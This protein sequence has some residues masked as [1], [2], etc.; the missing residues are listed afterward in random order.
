MKRV[1]ST[2][3]AVSLPLALAV[4]GTAQAESTGNATVSVLHGVPGLTVDVFANGEELIP[5]FEPGTLTDPLTIPAGTYDIQIFPDGEGPDGEPAI[6]APGVEVP[7]GVNATI[8][9]HLTE[10]GDPTATV[11]VNDLTGIEAGEA[12]V[13]ARHVAA[14]PAVDVRADG[15]VL[16]E[17]LTNPNEASADVPPGT[18][19][20]DVVLAGTEDVVLGPADLNLAEGT[21]TIAYAWGSAEEGTLDLAVQTVS[22]VGGAPDGVPA[23]EAGL[24]DSSSGSGAGWAL[25]AVVAAAV[26]GVFV[27]L[28][29]RLTAG[30]DN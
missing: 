6:E 5:D 9:A 26:L 7:A 17:G 27:V 16:F 14:A 22:G 2:A 20:A 4:A 29:R 8:V 30:A 15:D 11:F 25:G 1:I 3:A 23:G 12:R 18:V 19:S 13:V 21:S 10:G 24:L 28:R